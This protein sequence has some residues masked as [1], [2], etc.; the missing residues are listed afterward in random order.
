MLLAF[1][2]KIYKFLNKKWY[3]DQI[4]NEILILNI[5]NFGYSTTFLSLDKGLIEKFGP[6]GSTASI[7][8]LVSNF[9]SL[10]SGIL[11][12]NFLV[13]LFFVG[14]YY[15]MFFS[16]SFSLFFSLYFKI[17]LLSYTLFFFFRFNLF[18]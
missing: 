17:L 2:K 15:F 6:T 13:L 8:S 10:N 14:L 11:F 4:F 9:V 1:P 3:F 18:N 16:A 5:M 7:F 12:K